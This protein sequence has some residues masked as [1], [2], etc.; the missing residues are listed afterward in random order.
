MYTLSSDILSM[1]DEPA[2]LLQNR[3]LVFANAAARAILGEGCLGKGIRELFGDAGCVKLNFGGV[4]GH[5]FMV[6]TC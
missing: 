1:T 3:R 4:P 6:A 5:T 2:A